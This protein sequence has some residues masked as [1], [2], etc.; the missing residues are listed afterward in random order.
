MRP[1]DLRE[2]RERCVR[3]M[4]FCGVCGSRIMA[5][6]PT[7]TCGTPISVCLQGLEMNS[8]RNSSASSHISPPQAQRSPEPENFFAL[9]RRLV[10]Q[11]LLP[12]DLEGL[13]PESGSRRDDWTCCRPPR[14]YAP[15]SVVDELQ[16][17]S[18]KLNNKVL[19]LER[20]LGRQQRQHMIDED[21][22]KLVRI[23]MS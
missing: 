4:F 9:I 21:S 19:E 20:E 16:E 18:E 14:G 3:A 2:Q 15:L 1:P 22:S 23:R 8:A 13:G 17:H 12:R 6:G 10:D 7:L 5:D 11:A